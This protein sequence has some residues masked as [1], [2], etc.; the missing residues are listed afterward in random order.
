[1]EYIINKFLNDAGKLN[2]LNKMVSSIEQFDI[3]Q[4][5]FDELVRLARIELIKTKPII[6]NL[7]KSSIHLSNIL[8]SIDDPEVLSDIKSST[9]SIKLLTEKL[10]RISYKVDEILNDEELTNA[11]KDA[12]IG[13]GKLFNDIY[14]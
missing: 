2:V 6:I 9:R 5:N 1:M 12:A 3:T 11:F 14:D 8:A 4:K 13:I 7:E 10:D